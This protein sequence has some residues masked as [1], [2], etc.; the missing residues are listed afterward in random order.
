MDFTLV[1]KQLL[2]K[3]KIGELHEFC[4]NSYWGLRDDKDNVVIP[5][6]YKRRFID[7]YKYETNEDTLIIV[8]NSNSKKGVLSLKT[9]RFVVPD[10]YDK[11]DCEYD[12]FEG[13]CYFIVNQGGKRKTDEYFFTEYVGGK[14]GIISSR[15][16][17]II[18][19]VYNSLYIDDKYV[20]C[21]NSLY[22]LKGDF[23]V[24]GFSKFVL[25]NDYLLLYFNL[26]Q[27]RYE[28]SFCAVLDKDFDF[29]LT[30]K[31]NKVHFK[32]GKT[33]S[34]VNDLIKEYGS[35]MFFR[36]IVDLSAMDE[37]FVILNNPYGSEFLIE[38]HIDFNTIRK[39]FYNRTEEQIRNIHFD[40]FWGH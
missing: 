4:I 3:S 19:P 36:Y 12:F 21:D 20:V 24:G 40:D 38:E 33:F 16:D 27:N 10:V 30:N 28:D 26:Y 8:E 14:Y 22:N 13:T 18:E 31:G 11:I 2:E 5:A 34:D 17:I 29:L 7:E 23:L 39:D 15:G 35:E 32:L 6:K 1:F 9:F 25:F 37:R